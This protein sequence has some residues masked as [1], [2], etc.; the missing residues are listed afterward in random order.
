MTT[1]KISVLFAIIGMSHAFMG[2]G[3]PLRT[4]FAALDPFGFSPQPTPA[5]HLNV[6]ARNELQ[7]RAWTRTCA[8]INGSPLTCD[9]PLVCAYNT[10]QSFMACCSTDSGGNLLD[11]CRMT[12]RC[13]NQ[14]Q[15]ESLCS[16][17]SINCIGLATGIWYVFYHSLQWPGQANMDVIN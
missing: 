8:I 14:A 11:P 15:S 3:G 10:P 13:I 6:H 7:K 2:D 16:T 17:T 5:P 1:R 9:A 4:D 12:T